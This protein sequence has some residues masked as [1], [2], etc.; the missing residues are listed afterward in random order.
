MLHPKAAILYSVGWFEKKVI[1][2]SVLVSFRD[3]SISKFLC[4]RVTDLTR[5]FIHT[6]FSYVG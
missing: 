1:V 2:V 4:F 3:M 6:M 5:K